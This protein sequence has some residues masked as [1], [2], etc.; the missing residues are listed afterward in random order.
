MRAIAEKLVLPARL[1]LLVFWVYRARR[2]QLDQQGRK[3]RRDR[4]GKAA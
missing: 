3:V 2:E 1:V 4:R